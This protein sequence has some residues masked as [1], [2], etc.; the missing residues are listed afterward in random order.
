MNS[1]N[2]LPKLQTN[3]SVIEVIALSAGTFWSHS[4]DNTRMSGFMDC[5]SGQSR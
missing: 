5:D 4:I 2:Y 3:K 1:D